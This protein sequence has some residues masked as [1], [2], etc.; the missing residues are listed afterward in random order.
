MLVLEGE[1]SFR[2]PLP[3]SGMVLI[4]RDVEADLRLR[5]D[6]VSRRHARLTLHGGEVRVIDLDSHNGTLVNGRRVEGSHRLASGDVVTLGTVVAVLRTSTRAAAPAHTLEPEPLME[7]LRM[8]VER[9]LRYSRPLAVLTLALPESGLHREAVDNVCATEFHSAEAAG[10]MD[11][12]HLLVLLPE[13]AGETGEEDLGERVE[14]LAVA[15]PGARLGYAVCPTDGCDADT[16]VTASRSAAEGGPPGLLR[17]A[18]DSATRLS[19]GERSLLLADPAMVQLYAL[20]RRL[21]ASELPVLVNGETGVG[22]ENAAFAVHHWSRR[23]AG[24]FITLNCAAIPEGLVESEL[25][26]H[27][28][29]AFTGAAAPRTG[30]LESAHGGTIFLDEVGEL[31]LPVQAKLLRV[32]ETKRITRLGEARERSLDIR[33]VAATHRNL[34]ADAQAGRFRQDLYFRLGAATVLLPPLRERPR[35][36]SLLARSFLAQACHALGRREMIL[37][38]DTLQVL[39]HYRWPGNVRELR[40]L[41]DFAAAA[42][43]GDVLEP[44]HLPP[45]VTGAPTAGAP[46]V[47]SPPTP[48]PRKPLSE[49]IRELERRR[50]EEALQEAEGVQSHA[51]ALIGMPIR[52]FRFKMKQLGLT[53][54]GGQR[55]TPSP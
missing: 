27:E 44:H 1:S 33:I 16:L 21:A 5:D 3:A 37:S 11:D 23:S 52:T 10:W 38:A 18:S 19:L 35:E 51:A 4:G 45:R 40:N 34:E 47:G 46:P 24:P 28:K 31:P 12:G 42:G 26:G 17:A 54:R 2:F 53:A 13:V 8:E 15:C 49:E 41:M 22:K 30:H 43:T 55:G 32:L 14:A 20:I 39:S 25:F 50:M 48:T 7:R 9:S 29:G 36:I 6:S